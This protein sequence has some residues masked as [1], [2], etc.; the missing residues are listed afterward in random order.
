MRGSIESKVRL[1][2]TGDL[3]RRRRGSM[4]AT[5]LVFAVLS[6]G[7]VAF[8]VRFFIALRHELRGRRSCQVPRVG[9]NVYEVRGWRAD[10]PNGPRG[11]GNGNQGNGG[12][13]HTVDE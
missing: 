11:R 10:R 1:M 13:M 9:P 12:R 2:S 7:A 5:F 4:S 8:L 6:I 3:I